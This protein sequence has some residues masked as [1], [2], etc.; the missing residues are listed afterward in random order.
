MMKKK[1]KYFC[2]WLTVLSLVC[3]AIYRYITLNEYYS[4]LSNQRKE[5]Y[6][7]GEIVQF[8]E[9]YLNPGVCF[10]GYSIRVDKLEIVDSITYLNSIP[11]SIDP[12]AVVPEKLALVYITLF[13]EDS[14]AEGVMLTELG[15]HSIDNYATM[16]WELLT[17]INPILEGNYGIRLSPNTSYSLILPFSFYERYFASDTWNNLEE[18]TFYL[19]ITGYPVEKDIQIQ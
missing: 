11:N 13:N 3:A 8:G 6:S 15:F 19:H 10:N 12:N 9:N 18:C 2:T 17:V 7:A 16:D 4:S 14:D 5:I 1:V